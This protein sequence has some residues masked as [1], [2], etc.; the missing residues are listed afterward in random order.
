MKKRS[1]MVKKETDRHILLLYN[2]Y[3]GHT[4][5]DPFIEGS[6][7][8]GMQYLV[9]IFTPDLIRITSFTSSPRLKVLTKDKYYALKRSEVGDLDIS[10]RKFSV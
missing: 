3:A 4:R 10:L 7:A 8:R 9:K 2:I 1:P 5:T 6:Q